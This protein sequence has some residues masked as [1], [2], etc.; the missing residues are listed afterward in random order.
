MNNI[1]KNDSLFL[2]KLYMG[3]KYEQVVNN[4]YPLFVLLFGPFSL[5]YYNMFIQSLV[6]IIL[7]LITLLFIDYQYI[8]LMWLVY[9]FIIS[10]LFNKMYYQDTNYKLYRICQKLKNTNYIIQYIYSFHHNRLIITILCII[11]YLFLSFFS[12]SINIYYENFGNKCMI[13]NLTINYPRTYVIENNIIHNG[14]KS[15]MIEINYSKMF[16]E[17]KIKEYYSV[18]DDY[19]DIII[20]NQT[21]REYSKNNQKLYIYSYYNDSYYIITKN[22]E[23]TDNCNE[24]ISNIISTI[25]LSGGNVYE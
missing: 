25:E 13:E 19:Q 15:C 21:W 3:K 1:D 14:D 23:M 17:E 10:L 22:I 8:I 9:N 5:I 4:K 11:I 12:V 24:T 7:E 20:N 18:D 2:L 16:D 6:F